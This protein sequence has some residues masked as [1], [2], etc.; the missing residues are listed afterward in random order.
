MADSQ[1]PLIVAGIAKQIATATRL[2]HVY[3]Y[4]PDAPSS[5]PMFFFTPKSWRRIPET[6]GE[7]SIEWE[8]E[9]WAM[10]PY[11]NNQTAETQRA[12][13][14]LQIIGVSGHDLDAGE[15]LP[16]GQVLIESGEFDVGSIQGV[17]VL[18]ARFVIRASERIAYEYAL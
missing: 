7:M 1:L 15:A 17:K 12:T 11:L 3:T 9:G 2:K 4:L 13:L 6:Y 14:V 16:D 5:E 8:F 18:A 10:V